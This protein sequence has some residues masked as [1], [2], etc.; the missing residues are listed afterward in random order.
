MPMSFFVMKAGINSFDL[1]AGDEIGIFD[2][3]ICV[4]VGRLEGEIEPPFFSIVASKN[5]GDGNGFTEGHAVSYKFWDD[6]EGEEIEGVV[7]YYFDMSTGE[8][9]ENPPVF[10]GLGDAAVELWATQTAHFTGWVETGDNYLIIIFSIDLTERPISEGDEIG[11]FCAADNG[12]PEIL[13]GAAVCGSEAEISITAW[14]DDTLTP[15]QDGY[16]CGRDILFKLWYRCTDIEESVTASFETGNGT[17]CYGFYSEA[18]LFGDGP[19]NASPVADAGENQY[20]HLNNPFDSVLVELDGGN[21]YDCD[22][23]LTSWQWNW[24]NGFSTESSFYSYFGAGNHQA[25]LQVADDEDATDADTCEISIT[26]APHA[27]FIAEPTDGYAPLTVE[28]TNT[29]ILGTGESVSYYWNFGDG[30]TSSDENPSHIYTSVGTFDVALTVSTTD[31]TDISEFA[32]IIV[33]MSTLPTAVFTVEPDSGYVPL[34]VEFTNTS[35]FGTGELLYYLWHF[36]DGTISDD[37]NPVHI[38][39]ISGVFDVQLIISTT[40]GVDTSGTTIITVWD[41]IPPT[42]K[43]AMNPE[44]GTPPLEVEFTNLSDFGSGELQSYLWDFGDGETSNDENPVHIFQIAGTYK[45]TLTT[46]TTHGE[47]TSTPKMLVVSNNEEPPIAAFIAEPTDGYVPLTVEFTN[48]SI[49]G[50]GESVSYYWNF[51]DGETSN[52]ENP[53]HIYAEAGN[54]S[55][56]LTVETSHGTSTS[57]TTTIAVY[58][59]IPPTAVFTVEPDSGYVPLTVEFTN[60]SGF[61]TGEL[62]YYLW[63][64]GDGTISDDENPVHIYEISGVF[65][66]QLIISTTHGSDSYFVTINVLS[67]VGIEENLVIPENYFLRYNYP[68]P[69]NATTIIEFGLPEQCRCSIVIYDLLGNQISV[70]ADSEFYPGTYKIKWNGKNS[71]FQSVPSGIYLYFMH[72][73]KFHK[74]GK[75]ILLR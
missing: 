55:V 10:A 38:Y 52:D 57:E 23:E 64:F 62:L 13:C 46:T 11:V 67:P 29:S 74:T 28:F 17:F 37:E 5:D 47:N 50:T 36:G 41:L 4:G 69:F 44:G 34:T 7:P 43:F 32:T 15:E 70:L 45:I 22:G 20:F 35:G 49:L 30:E 63:H 73:E 58:A 48:T 54:Y 60:T 18:N 72:T 25:V 12:D 53:T 6:S 2:G 8:P 65:D 3:E 19:E 9:L 75:M 42:A 24:E 68:N 14:K 51:G 39:E 40:H 71:S 16:V 33:R 59:T 66:V 21:S 27:S 61:G 31:G 1:G 26:A 56:A